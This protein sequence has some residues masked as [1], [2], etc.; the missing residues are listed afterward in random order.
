VTTIS[1]APVSFTAGA[2]WLAGSGTT[3]NTGAHSVD[4]LHE[5]LPFIVTK[6]SVAPVL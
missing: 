1:R 3:P 5:L 6:F 4:S 2:A